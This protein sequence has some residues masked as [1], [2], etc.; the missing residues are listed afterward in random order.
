MSN[1]LVLNFGHPVDIIQS[2]ALMNTLK[3]NPEAKIHVLTKTLNQKYVDL[4]DCADHVHTLDTR[5]IQKI[6][7]NPIYSDGHALN[8]YQ[9]SLETIL[10]TEWDSIINYSND[11]F[12]AYIMSALQA[13]SRIGSYINDQGVAQTSGAWATYQN[14][15]SPFEA[16]PAFARQEIKARVASTTINP[17]AGV[18]LTTQNNE[19]AKQ[20][21]SQIRKIKGGTPR[22]VVGISL[23]DSFDRTQY[24][25]RD[26]DLLLETLE[27]S[28]EFQT[29]LLH[30]NT[31][32]Q[33]ELITELNKKHQNKLVSVSLS[34]DTASAVINNIDLLVAPSNHHLYI[35]DAL[36]KNVVHIREDY[37]ASN[38]GDLITPGSYTVTR[39]S[40][41]P[42]ANEIIMAINERFDVY[43]PIEVLDFQ[44]K[45]FVTFNDN[46]GTS[47]SQIRGPIDI[48]AEINF[49]IKRM[50]HANALGESVQPQLV[51]QIKNLVPQQQIQGYVQDANQCLIDVSKQL[52]TCIRTLS[53]ARE[54]QERSDIFL[55]EVQS[56]FSL[57]QNN[58]LVAGNIL[59]LQ[60]IIEN[61]NHTD[62]NEIYDAIEGYL[63]K[64]KSEL[65]LAIKI[66]DD[67]VRSEESI[68]RPRENEIKS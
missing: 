49:H 33:R 24:S 16:I 22:H 65:Q 62:E 4:I 6:I 51:E 42:I 50:L 67:L 37:S 39:F 47:T 10:N 56:L 18:K 23:A 54:H 17:G 7:A 43:L 5:L 32:S 60:G 28:D 35:A 30:E 61:L 2:A 48:N 20:N 34:L 12:S 59:L 31:V 11:N 8:L 27:E 44:N 25:F 66:L 29:L 21:I 3:T 26:L 68:E 64:L 9:E 13:D 46:L 63:F 58:S 14:H 1:I 38:H 53:D 57:S 15:V 41:L 45:T 52:L 40:D 36:G 55:Q 19:N